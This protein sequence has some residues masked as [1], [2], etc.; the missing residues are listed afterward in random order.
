MSGSHGFLDE[1]R[2]RGVVRAALLYVAAAFALLEFADIAFPRLGLPD[3]AVNWVLWIGIAGF[4]L[5]MFAAW[6]IE[7]RAE[8]DT[9]RTT[10][11]LSPATI[12]TAAALIGLGAAMGFWWGGANE[13][14]LLQALRSPTPPPRPNARGPAVAVLRFADLSGSDELF[15][16]GLTEE[17]S[18]VLGGFPGLR[19]ISPSATSHFDE[20]DGDIRTLDDDLGVQYL[21]RGTVQRSGGHVRVAAQLLDASNGDQLWGDRY[22]AELVPAELFQTQDEIAVRVASTIGDSTGVLVQLAQERVRGRA[23]DSVEA[24]G[25]VLLGKSYF[26]VHTAEVHAR[27][28]ECLE[29]AVEIEPDYADAWAYLAYMYREEYLHRYPGKPAPLERS[30]AAA[31]RA[32]DLDPNNPMAHFSMAFTAASQYSL[33]AAVMEME[34]VAALSPNDSGMLG[35]VSI[36]LAHAGRWDR[37]LEVAEQIDRLNPLSTGWSHYTRAMAH[38]RAGHVDEALAEAIQLNPNDVQTQIHLTAIYARLGRTAAAR[39]SAE[40]LLRMD[41]HFAADPS[42]YLR[43]VFLRDIAVERYTEALR[44]AGLEIE[45]GKPARILRLGR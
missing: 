45:P 3:T 2:K 10:R 20:A 18:T 38:Y 42:E 30:A 43:R 12:V 40:E 5:A 15:T 23:P 19:V 37:A 25:C 14:G 39:A 41:A 36:Y 27:A 6:A 4:P 21:L 22:D 24:Y 33:D 28:R 9:G 7:L 17:I 34:R 44:L 8:R 11:W 1:L 35:G 29:G 31:R 16:V 26:K 13:G 32:I